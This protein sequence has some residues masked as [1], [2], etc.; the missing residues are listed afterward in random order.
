MPNGK[1]RKLLVFLLSL[2]ILTLYVSIFLQFTQ[3]NYQ[4][5]DDSNT[6]SNQQNYLKNIDSFFSNK[7]NSKSL[8]TPLDNDTQLSELCYFDQNQ[9]YT[10]DLCQVDDFLY[11]ANGE[12]GLDIY[13]ISNRSS[14]IKIAT[15][16]D[17]IFGSNEE[18]RKIDFY[19]NYIYT[20]S[21]FGVLHRVNVSNPNNPQQDKWGLGGVGKGSPSGDLKIINGTLYWGSYYGKDLS[22]YDLSYSPLFRERG[23]YTNQQYSNEI[24]LLEKIAYIGQ[25]GG[26]L[27]IINVSN[28]DC[29]T[30]IKTYETVGNPYIYDLLIKNHLLFV[31]GSLDGIDIFDITNPIAPVKVGNYS[32]GKRLLSISPLNEEQNIYFIGNDQGGVEII[33][34]SNPSVP[35]KIGEYQNVDGEGQ[36]ESLLVSDNILY[37]AA[38]RGGLQIFDIQ[39]YSHPMKITEFRNNEGVANKVVLSEDIA[40]IANG[41]AGFRIENISNPFDIKILCDFSTQKE[42]VDLAL[43]QINSDLLFVVEKNFGLEIFDISN[44]LSPQNIS[45]FPIENHLVESLIV[46]NGLIYLLLDSAGL[47]IINVTTPTSPHKINQFF[48]DESFR[49]FCLQNDYL[50]C[51]TADEIKIINISIPTDPI[52]IGVINS[53]LA[54]PSSLTIANDL[55]FINDEGELIIYN[56][57]IIGAPFV[58]KKITGIPIAK[59]FIEGNYLYILSD[60][61]HILNITSINGE[62]MFVLEIPYRGSIRGGAFG[63]RFIYCVLGK[64]DSLVLGFD[65]DGDRIADLREEL[66]ETNPYEEDTDQD[67]M[68]DYFE[69][70]YS[71]NPLVNDSYSNPDNDGLTNIEEFS[72]FLNPRNPDTDFDRI[73]DGIEQNLYGTKP[74]H[75]DSDRDRL[76]DFEEIQIFDTNPLNEDSDN[77]Q[78]NDYNEIFLYL[79]DPLSND[80][81]SDGLPDSYELKNDFNPLVAD[82]SDDSDNDGL[83]NL[84][85]YHLE[86]NPWVADYDGDGLLDGEEIHLYGTSPFDSDTDDDSLTDYQEVMEY[87]TNPLLADSDG[88]QFSDAEEISEG[89][90]PN[91]PKDNPEIRSIKNMLSIILPIF[92]GVLLI[93]LLWF[94][95]KKV[96]RKKIPKNEV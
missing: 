77:D 56:I 26:K 67:G 39:N 89:T 59:M 32:S 93:G 3:K 47:E 80:S 41:K 69:W 18:L 43:S 58:I 61:I 94:I 20:L 48:V 8:F 13:D 66:L 11:V 36:I 51:S 7:F 31:V 73:K 52:E 10:Y 78:L 84:E 17:C 21:K 4:K 92:G 57:T 24:T 1:L 29:P 81:D 53:N 96:I 25:T 12:N 45:Q 33:D 71:L 54:N 68:S 38:G 15:N 6:S 63:E 74:Y 82:S 76:F 42:V 23:S 35:I 49:E 88:D 2:F 79:T 28:I 19:N 85:E 37:L 72:L 55:L 91:D 50:F 87:Q 70:L 22:I 14:P 83:T 65:R 95:F 34:F 60:P 40:F 44:P 64:E 90:D 9:G 30:L 62:E 27:S 46:E 75:P 16:Y 5:V 86:L